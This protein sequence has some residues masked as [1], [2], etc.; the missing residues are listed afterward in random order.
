MPR[1]THSVVK[2]QTLIHKSYAST[3]KFLI[4]ASSA[5]RQQS[6]DWFIVHHVITSIRKFVVIVWYKGY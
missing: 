5:N 6:P 3:V 2:L 4:L 1:A